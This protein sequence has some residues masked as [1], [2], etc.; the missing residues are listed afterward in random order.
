MNQCLGP[1]KLSLVIFFHSNRTRTPHVAL[2]L[3]YLMHCLKHVGYCVEY[4]VTYIAGNARL[5]VSL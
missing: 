1:I 2:T 4:R 5:K 3:R